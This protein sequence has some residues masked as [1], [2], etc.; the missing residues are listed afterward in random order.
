MNS[1]SISP[2]YVLLN[3]N[4]TN[5][6]QILQDISNA[7][8]LSSFYYF[9]KLYYHEET[10]SLVYYCARN[11]TLLILEEDG[12]TVQGIIPTSIEDQ[13]NETKITCDGNSIVLLGINGLY[14]SQA[15]SSQMIVINMDSKTVTSHL[16]FKQAA[17]GFASD[18]LF[19][20]IITNDFS[21]DYVV[22]VSI[23]HLI[24]KNDYYE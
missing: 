24:Y 9:S 2:S 1:T 15:T 20:Y 16:Y 18:G 3:F 5:I 22:G 12:F 13:F 14:T 23:Y 11:N 10:S 6:T 17:V 8:D 4:P 21:Q 7:C 19:R